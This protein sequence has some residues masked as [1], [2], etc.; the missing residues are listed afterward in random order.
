MSLSLGSVIPMNASF[1]S[2]NTQQPNILYICPDQYRLYALSIWSDPA[3]RHILTTQGDPVSTPNIDRLAKSGILFTQAT[4]THPLSSPHRAMLLSGMYPNKNGIE[5]MNC[6]LGRRQELKHDIECFTDVLAQVGYETAYIG[7]TH[8]HKTEALF[9]KNGNFVNSTTEPGGHSIN[10]FD[11]YVPE[12][13]SRHQ[14]NYWYQQLNDNHYNPIA[15][16]NQP[17]LIDGKKD[18]EQF[19]PRM[20]STTKEADVIMDYLDNR[21]GQRDASKPFSIFWS[22][23]PPHNPYYSTKDC[24]SAIY[25]AMY[26]NMPVEQ[27]LVRKNVNLSPSRDKNKK[28]FPADKYAGIYFSLIK[29][30]DNEIGRVIDHLEKLGLLDKTLIVFTS[31]HG[32]MMGSHNLGGKGLIYDESF[33]VPFIISYPKLLKP[34]VSD[35]LLGSVDIMPT[36]LGMIGYADQIPATVQG[37]N[38]SEGLITGKYTKTPKPKSALYLSYKSRGIRTDRYTFTIDTQGVY[39]IF[40]NQK[41]PFQLHEL[42]MEQLPSRDQQ[43]LKSE[44]GK[45]LVYSQDSWCKNKLN[46]Q[47][48]DYQK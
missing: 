46:A 24:D 48:I 45:W 29:S 33:L 23:N 4:S 22:I 5:G 47:L 36:L 15:Y 44:L 32:E 21:K 38:Y 17:D 26:K 14:N 40:D 10:P 18:G 1:K 3:F 42:K 34:H 19:R 8:W 27:L 12:G 13:K 31:D 11:T 6:K 30:V 28:N 37:Q 16:S 41:D 39:A 9:D 43:L 20:F 2:Q 7:K 25:N 35:L